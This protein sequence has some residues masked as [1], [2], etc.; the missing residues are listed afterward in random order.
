M[1]RDMCYLDDNFNIIIIP[2]YFVPLATEKIQTE[3]SAEPAKSYI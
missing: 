1:T 2:K 3:L